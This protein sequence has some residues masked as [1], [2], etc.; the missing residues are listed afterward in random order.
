MEFLN[1]FKDLFKRPES[2][3]IEITMSQ[4][5]LILERD[6]QVANLLGITY[7]GT[8]YIIRRA[9]EI[10]EWKQLGITQEEKQLVE[11]KTESLEKKNRDTRIQ[12]CHK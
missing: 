8:V 4:E 1:K 6:K 7:P 5:K 3:I 12:K 10:M 11:S 2:E 9:C